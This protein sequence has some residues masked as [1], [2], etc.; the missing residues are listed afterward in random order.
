MQASEQAKPSVGVVYDTGMH[1][2]CEALALA[3]LYGFE[4]KNEA[5]LTAVSVSASNLNAA[6][7]CEAVGQFYTSRTMP[8][9]M[10]TDGKLPDDSPLFTVPLT[11]RDADGKPVY[12]TTIR[13]LNDTADAPALIRNV[14]T[15]QVDGN[16]VVIMSGPASNLARLLALRGVNELIK[17]KV[18]CLVIAAGGYP[19][20]QPDPYLLA[21]IPAAKRLLAEWP[22]PVV[23]CGSEVGAALPFP[24]AALE[25]DFAWSQAH[26]V[27]DAYRAYR[28]MPYDAPADALAAA[29]YAVHP[30]ENYFR[31][32]EPG[33]IRVA[34]DGRTR[35]SPAADGKHRYLLVDPAQKDRV[36]KVFE[37]VASAKPVPRTRPRPPA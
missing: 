6:A 12:R 3:L 5:R 20:G 32:S 23:A 13:K 24:A 2:S 9:G 36:M 37:E 11:R 17:Q 35:F 22:G 26:P 10:S 34:T 27:A 16:A 33:T 30:M 8:V 25:R 1:R 31:L 18:R 28:P 14:F 7:Y 21:D 15:A 29:L 19:E 4:G